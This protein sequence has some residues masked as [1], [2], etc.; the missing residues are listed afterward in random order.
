MLRH[1]EVGDPD[2]RD[3]AQRIRNNGSHLL[4]I[5]NEVL[6]VSKVEFGQI[7]LEVQ[8]CF[9]HDFTKEL[10]LTLMPQAHA[11]NNQLDVFLDS[12]IP[13][14]I[15][16]DPTRLR[17]ILLNVIGNALKFT[18]SGQVKVKISYLHSINQ[19]CWTIEDSGI[20]LTP[21]QVARLFQPFSQGDS[22]HSRRF[23][24]TGLGLSLSRKL[25]RCLGGDV[26]LVRTEVG[27][28]SAFQVLIAHKGPMI[29][30]FFT[31][32]KIDKSHFISDSELNHSE[33]ELD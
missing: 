12:E 22:S 28:G 31:D 21:Q 15:H 20:G 1:L 9:V 26:T 32:L 3:W 10:I 19:L 14:V 13:A 30:E 18:K 8:P 25:A 11:N 24:G 17:Q 27:L 16:T 5:V 23:G 6:D 4:K 33:W 29:T 2:L 7:E